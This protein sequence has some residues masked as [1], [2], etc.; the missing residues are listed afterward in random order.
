MK[1]FD[2]KAA[3]EGALLITRNREHKNLKVYEVNLGEVNLGI[4]NYLTV[5]YESLNQYK[6]YTLDGAY[7]NLVQSNYDLFMQEDSDLV[8]EV[9]E[10]EKTESLKKIVNELK[11]F[12][13]KLDEMIEFCSDDRLILLKNIEMK[14]FCI[15]EKLRSLTND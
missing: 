14:I 15:Y 3:L 5:K 13:I 10:K 7:Y 8:E 2:L 12:K 1:P 9:E 11:D 6:T 4:N